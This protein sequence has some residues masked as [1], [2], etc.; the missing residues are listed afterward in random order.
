MPHFQNKS[1]ST[2]VHRQFRRFLLCH[3][4]SHSTIQIP[5]FIGT[6]KAGSA[7]EQLS[8]YAFPHS[9]TTDCD[10]RHFEIQIATTSKITGGQLMT[11][12]SSIYLW[13]THK[14]HRT[15]RYCEKRQI[16]INPK[17]SCFLEKLGKIFFLFFKFFPKV[18]RVRWLCYCVHWP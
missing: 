5:R 17:I 16:A 6:P 3:C 9:T 8:F 10:Q 7:N 18:N 1:N 2:K 4:H 11:H 13:G 14:L 15:P 12:F